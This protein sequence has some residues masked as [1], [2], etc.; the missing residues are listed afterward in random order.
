MSTSSVSSETDNRVGGNHN[1]GGGGDDDQPN[2]E[3]ERSNDV[4][5]NVIEGVGNWRARRRREHEDHHE[6]PSDIDNGSNDSKIESS[7]TVNNEDGNATGTSLPTATA[8]TINPPLTTK[9]LVSQ[10]DQV[11]TIDYNALEK[12]IDV[13]KEI[14]YGNIATT[15]EQ[16]PLASLANGATS[17]PVQ[18]NQE[19]NEERPS[20]V[21]ATEPSEENMQGHV[22]GQEGQQQQPAEG[23]SADSNRRQ[24][25]NRR[26]PTQPGAVA[27]A[28][29][30]RRT[31]TREVINDPDVQSLPSEGNIQNE[32]QPPDATSLLDATLVDEDEME[33]RLAA[34][35][36]IIRQ[37]V[38]REV[39]GNE[40]E[41]VHSH[42]EDGKES[43]RPS[44]MMPALAAIITITALAVGLSV[45]LSTSRRGL[46]NSIKTSPT[47]SP[48]MAPT[49]D[50]CSMCYGGATLTEKIMDSTSWDTIIV[51]QTPLLTCQDIFEETIGLKIWD[52]QC[53][54]FR[55]D[56]ALKC[57]CPTF[58]PI[59]DDSNCNLCDEGETVIP[60]SVDASVTTCDRLSQW[61]SLLGQN[62]SEET[63]DRLKSSA[64]ACACVDGD[65]KEFSQ[66]EEGIGFNGD[67]DLGDLS[68][69]CIDNLNLIAL[70]ETDANVDQ[71][72]ERRYVLCPHTS[73]K[74]GI[75][76][77][78]AFGTGS[79]VVDGQLPIT[80]GSNFR[81]M[82]GENGSSSNNCT[83]H[84]G[85]FGVFLSN[86]WSIPGSITQDNVHF[87]GITFKDVANPIAAY[88]VANITIQD[89]IFE[90]C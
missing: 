55:A 32:S 28:P 78:E 65:G 8:T 45:G 9:M 14:L 70:S 5:G 75:A 81:V 58:P 53:S 62:A 16:R 80:G 86:G 64:F 69:S 63:C 26:V 25:P 40:A 11:N 52:Y 22:H 87:Q 30:G 51:Q 12:Q 85:T 2:N 47:E 76:N 20:S 41:L 17:S 24:H 74:V 79:A 61:V 42:I 46:P 23:S 39:A 31:E 54:K 49:S 59:P 68:A 6:Q 15:M 89:C 48:T 29:T 34:E 82:C 88:S 1:H 27:V 38:L 66:E 35:R 43:S 33:A 18:P 56:A 3:E 57:G 77:L 84:D 67:L 71:S 37:D 60:T 13:K 83:I 72:T 19:E 90:V 4:E 36:D 21:N 10:L 7:G 44:W 73:F 50:D